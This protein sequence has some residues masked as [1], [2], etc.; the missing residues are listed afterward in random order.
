MVISWANNFYNQDEPCANKAYYSFH[1]GRLVIY[2][3]SLFLP[4]LFKGY[5]FGGEGRA[6]FPPTPT[7]GGDYPPPQGRGYPPATPTPAGD[8]P[9]PSTPGPPSTPLPTRVGP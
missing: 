6:L 5:W 8:Y 1:L 4:L 9:P 3:E 2:R 7:P